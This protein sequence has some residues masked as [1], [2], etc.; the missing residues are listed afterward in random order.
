MDFDISLFFL[1]VAGIRAH[2]VLNLPGAA[3]Q[4]VECRIET[5]N[6]CTEKLI[7]YKFAPL[8]PLLSDNIRR[9]NLILQIHSHIVTLYNT[10]FAKFMPVID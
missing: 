3:G 9:F 6:V 5:I 2:G 8:R 4:K 10:R 1:Y 7:S